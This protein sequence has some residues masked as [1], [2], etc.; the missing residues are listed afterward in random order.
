MNQ[1][2]RAGMVFE[3]RDKNYVLVQAGD[4]VSG[5]TTI[6]NGFI[7]EAYPDMKDMPNT[8][9]FIHAVPA[10]IIQLKPVEP[11]SFAG[12]TDVD[13]ALGAIAKKAGLTLE[14]NGVKAILASPYFPGTAWSQIL[15]C[16]QAADCFAYLDGITKT[17][18]VWPKNSSRSGGKTIVSPDTGM[19]GYPQF[20]L[21]NILVRTLFTTEIRPTEVGRV[22]QVKSQ[23]QAA[24]GD[25]TVISVVHDLISEM[26]GGPWETTFLATPVK[27]L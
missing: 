27:Q 25:F 6:F 11:T 10:N 26:P 13:T 21:L 3:Q 4:D 14:N 1:M 5:M 7:V 23:L 2:S 9:F 20:Q 24:N 8:S 18:A 19:I 16:V 17:L 12:A 22:V 15:S